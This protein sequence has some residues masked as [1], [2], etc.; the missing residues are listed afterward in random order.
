MNHLKEVED[1]EDIE[2][3]RVMGDVSRE[4]PAFGPIL[5]QQP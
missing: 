1:D 3:R 2:Q 5:K 4:T